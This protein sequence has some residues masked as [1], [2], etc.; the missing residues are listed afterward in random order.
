MGLVLRGFKS[1]LKTLV[2]KNEQLHEVLSTPYASV[3]DL[4]MHVRTI[5]TGENNPCGALGRAE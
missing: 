5:R 3:S 1:P 4:S 2:E